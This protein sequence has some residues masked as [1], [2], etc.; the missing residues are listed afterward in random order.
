MTERHKFSVGPFQ[1]WL[2]GPQHWEVR[3]RDGLVMGR[4]KNM[5]E[6]ATLATRF[7]DQK[8][9]LDEAKQVL[10]TSNNHS[11]ERVEQSR[12]TFAALTRRNT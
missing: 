1:G 2:C 6:C 11:P 12:A 7:N 4:A 9:E 8:K 3:H 5:M 10:E